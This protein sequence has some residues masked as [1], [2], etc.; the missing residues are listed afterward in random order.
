MSTGYQIGLIQQSVYETMLQKQRLTE[1]EIERAEKTVIAPSAD[2]NRMLE[3]RG[4][5]PVSTGAK[6]ADL[7]RRPQLDYPSL[8]PFDPQRPELPAPVREQ[9]EIRLKYEGYIRRQQAMAQDFRRMEGRKLPEGIDYAAIQGIR[10]EAR[11]KLG[12]VRPENLGQAGRI[13]GVNPADLTALMIYLERRA[14]GN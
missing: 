8:A 5:S 14:P 7:V 12:A 3:D 6:L 13:P 9:V 4:T 2:L 11:E 10:L 1:R